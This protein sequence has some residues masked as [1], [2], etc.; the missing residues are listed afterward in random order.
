MLYIKLGFIVL[1]VVSTSLSI[2]SIL[3]SNGNLAVSLFY[4]PL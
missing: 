1:P 3:A 2:D 4:I